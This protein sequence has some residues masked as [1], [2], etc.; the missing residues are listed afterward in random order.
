MVRIALMLMVLIFAVPTPAV[1]QAAVVGAVTTVA[2]PQTA[3]SS[4]LAPPRGT[5]EYFLYYWGLDK[6]SETFRNF[7]LTILASIGL[8]FGSWRAIT[9]HRQAKA[10]ETLATAALDQARN[11]TA[12]LEISEQGQITDRYTKAVEMLSN[13]HART[14]VGAVYALG[15]IAQDSVERDH[16][17]VMEVLTEFI[18]NPPYRTETDE[19]ADARNR[20]DYPPMA[21]RC[22]DIHAVL[23]VIQDRNNGQRMRERAEG[24]APNFHG[25]A[26][27]E[28]D[29]TLSNFTGSILSE[30]NLTGAKLQGAYL[31]GASLSA[32]NLYGA[33]LDRADLYRADLRKANLGDVRNLTQYQ[34]ESARPT[35]P[36]HSLPDGLTWPFV[37]RNG[38][39]VKKD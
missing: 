25:A 7:A 2:T 11:A 13:K 6:R 12:Q 5:L 24:F 30:A 4:K 16:I 21:I 9:A 28:L 1:A 32:A 3:S 29:L 22:R 14:R 19:R 27:R 26:L 38:E 36:A 17:A 8:V 15:R 33:D 34:L 10:S 35:A 20:S 18:R 39:W 23:N 37:Q 31:R